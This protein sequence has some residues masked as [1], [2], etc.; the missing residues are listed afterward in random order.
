MPGVKKVSQTR[1][2]SLDGVIMPRAAL[3]VAGRGYVTRPHRFSQ[4]ESRRH[5]ASKLYYFFS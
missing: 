2:L 1:G 5:F 3:N 4:P